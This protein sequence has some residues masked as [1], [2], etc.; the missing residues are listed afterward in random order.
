MVRKKEIEDYADWLVDCLSSEGYV[1]CGSCSGAD[2]REDFKGL[3]MQGV[4]YADSHHWYPCDGDYLPD[5]DEVVLVTLIW[6][7]DEDAES[8]YDV[9][10]AHRSDNPMVVVDK[11]GFAK[12]IE[13]VQYG[14]WCRI[15]KFTK[16]K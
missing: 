5:Y 6:D 10:F 15:P 2:P 4:D 1:S 9:T 14:H 8:E 16:Q 7:D 13:G 11:N 3:F 12:V